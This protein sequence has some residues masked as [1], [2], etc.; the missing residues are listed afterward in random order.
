MGSIIVNMIRNVVLLA[1]V[2]LPTVSFAS[3]P[4]LKVSKSVTIH[5]TPAAVWAKAK[6]FD[7]LN[8]WHPAVVKDE[9]VAGTNNKPGAERELT[10]GDGGKIHEKLLSFDDKHHSFRYEILD[11]VLP[12]TSY[13]STFTV[14]AA[15]KGLS[16]VSWAGSFK[17][18]DTGPHPA[19]NANDAT[20]IKVIGGVYQSGLDNL[21]KIVETK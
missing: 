19:A 2:A 10:L 13:K 4:V 8:T 9:L 6:N 7:G 18:K 12:V 1:F 11:G 14:K 5:A 17:R 16:K 3:A 15:G 21:K 20:A